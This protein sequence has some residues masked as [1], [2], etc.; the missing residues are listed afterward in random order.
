MRLDLRDAHVRLC[1]EAG[2]LVSVNTDAHGAGDFDELPF[3]VA[4][5]RRGGLTAE[6]CINCWP[7]AKL[8]AW[9]RAKR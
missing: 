7:Q 2:C 6:R 4:T 8:L 3:G 9:A 1:M 5:A